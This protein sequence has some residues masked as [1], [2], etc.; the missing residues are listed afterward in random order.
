LLARAVGPDLRRDLDAL[1]AE[2]AEVAAGLAAL[3][4]QAL[5]FAAATHF[6][7]TSN[8]HPTGGKARPIFLLR[9]G[10]EKNPVREVGPG[11]VACVPG[12]PSRF[13]AGP[14][15]QRRAALARW[16][17]DPRNPLTW[18]SAVNR[19]WQYHFGQGIVDT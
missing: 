10:S 6:A 1:A 3:P 16:V 9:R 2:R 5:V 4:P 11:T 19:A 7:P 15:A 14:E 13:P 18:R 8:F 12:L 17:T